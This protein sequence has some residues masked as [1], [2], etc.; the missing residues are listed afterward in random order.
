MLW[1]NQKQP[2]TPRTLRKAGDYKADQKLLG[3]ELTPIHA[4]QKSGAKENVENLRG[5]QEI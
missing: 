1:G 4:N 5:N 2:Q 3:R